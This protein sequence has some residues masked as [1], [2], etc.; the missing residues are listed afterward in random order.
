MKTVLQLD[1]LILRPLRRWLPVLRGA[2]RSALHHHRLLRGPAGRLDL[3]PGAAI[4]DRRR[5]RGDAGRDARVLGGDVARGTEGRSDAVVSSPPAGG[6]IMITIVDY[7]MGNLGSIRNMLK[8]VG[9]ESRD[10]RRRRRVIAARRQARSCPASARSTPACDSLERA[11]CVADARRERVAGAACRCSASASACSCW[12]AAARRARCPGLG[13][14][15]A[16]TLPLPRQR[17]AARSRCR[18]WAGTSLEPRATDAARRRTC[19]RAALLLRALVLRRAATT[20]R[21][22]PDDADYGDAF[23]AAFASATTSGACS[24]TP[25]RATASACSCCATSRSAC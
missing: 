2:D 23:L 6:F 15:D 9:V 20:R 22:A 21:R 3:S 1:A 5:S 16:E 4:G 12:R 17:R 11:G 18:T 7:G 25:R 10:H 24:S 8:K 13:W 14:I 19:R